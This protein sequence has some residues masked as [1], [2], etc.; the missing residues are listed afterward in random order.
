MYAQRTLSKTARLCVRL[1]F[2]TYLDPVAKR[3]VTY[4]S[5]HVHV[6]MTEHF[7]ENTNSLVNV[8]RAN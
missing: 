2:Y 7:H 3:P 1:A 4:C 8:H 6:I 5:M